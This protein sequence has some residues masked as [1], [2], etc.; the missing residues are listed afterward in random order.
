MGILN[1]DDHNC[2]E[3]LNRNI[4]PLKYEVGFLDQV[5][6][7]S[8][9]TLSK[10]KIPDYTKD[11]RNVYLFIKGV[12]TRFK[13]FLDNLD[14]ADKGVFQ[15]HRVEI[16]KKGINR[17]E[18]AQRLGYLN[19]TTNI[20]IDE[21]DVPYSSLLLES[22][23]DF[24]DY[25]VDDEWQFDQEVFNNYVDLEF[26]GYKN[27]LKC[28]GLFHSKFKMVFDKYKINWPDSD[29]DDES[30]IDSDEIKNILG[31]DYETGSDSDSD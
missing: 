17:L 19:D 28:I 2:N 29:S 31:I 9:A 5:D 7:N 20:E 24:G 23:A 16:I 22:L 15:N 10:S 27:L 11:Y 21:Q 6:H 3:T 18:K 1:Q 25:Y 13:F 8:N 4:T 14:K 26:P 12:D 30:G